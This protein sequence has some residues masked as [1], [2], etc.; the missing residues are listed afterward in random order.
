[1]GRLMIGIHTED[2]QA[3]AQT[4]NYFTIDCPL[5][6]NE[7]LNGMC[8]IKQYMD[9]PTLQRRALSA[10][11]GPRQLDATSLEKAFGPQPYY[12]MEALESEWG[13]R[14]AGEVSGKGADLDAADEETMTAQFML[15][16]RTG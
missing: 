9:F 5:Q 8:D 4:K 10:H 11:N 1:M 12:V 14:L 6:A 15:G 2:D 13:R 16:W 7:N 3:Q